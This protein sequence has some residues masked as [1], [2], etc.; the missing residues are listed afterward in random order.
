[1]SALLSFF[2]GTAFRMIW[3]ELSSYFTAKQ[4]HQHELALMEV[5]GKLKAA[6]HER[7]L[8]A[9]K[10]QSDLGIKE[11]EVKSNAD[12]ALEE[13]RAWATAVTDVGRSTGIKWLDAWNGSIRPFLA[14]LAILMVCVEITALG[15]VLTDW[16]RELFGAI[17]GIFVADRSL[18]N[19]GK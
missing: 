13:L 18:K 6:E 9:M 3:G 12:Q 19:R 1:M 4:E 8:A 10:L 11:I 15:F 17:L 16:H 5:E 14:T 2:G 7:N